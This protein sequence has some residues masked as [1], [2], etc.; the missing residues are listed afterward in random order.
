MISTPQERLE[1]L[2]KTSP[3]FAPGAENYL[4]MGGLEDIWSGDLAERL[5]TA[6]QEQSDSDQR[7]ARGAKRGG[8]TT[9]LLVSERV[10]RDAI[11]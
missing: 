5:R 7:R 11:K 6:L 8:R 3:V 10:R 9:A 4:K 1:Q 2:S